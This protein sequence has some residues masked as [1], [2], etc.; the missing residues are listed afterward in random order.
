MAIAP[1]SRCASVDD[2]VIR[3]FLDGA[4]A[5]VLSSNGICLKPFD[6]L[7]PLLFNIFIAAVLLIVLQRFSEE[8]D[9]LAELVNLQE[10]PRETRPE[11]MTDCGRRVVWGMLCAD[12][13]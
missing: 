7:S 11:S 13:V 4:K 6:V 5:C 10:Q 1:S 8:A 12:D 2:N 9:F 3:E